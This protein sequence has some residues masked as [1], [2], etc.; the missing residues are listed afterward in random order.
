LRR[1]WLPVV[2]FTALLLSAVPAP[3]QVRPTTAAIQWFPSITD[4]IAAKPDSQLPMLLFLWDPAERWDARMQSILVDS[5]A[6][7]GLLQGF[8]PV[9]LKMPGAKQV[10]DAYGLRS[11]P[12]LAVVSPSGRVLGS[13]LGFQDEAGCREFL[14]QS[15]GPVGKAVVAHDLQQ[16]L[17]KLHESRPKALD[18]FAD[19]DWVNL[20][21]AMGSPAWRQEVRRMMLELDPFPAAKLVEHLEHPRLAVRL[22][23][24]ELLEERAGDSLDFDPWQPGGEASVEALRKW[25]EWAQQPAGEATRRSYAAITLADIAECL[26]DLASADWARAARAR[27]RLLSGGDGTVAAAAAYLERNPG[28]PAGTVQLLR[29]VQFAACLQ[30]A[31]TVDGERLARQLAFGDLD[32]R[33]AAVPKLARASLAAVPILRQLLLSDEPLVREVAADTLGAIGGNTAVA[34]LAEHLHAE[35]DVD[36]VI[37]IASRL[38]KCRTKRSMLTLDGLLKH[39]DEDVRVA[40][41]EALGRFESSL[42]VSE[43]I[44]AAL[45]DESWRTRAGA[46]ACIGES[47]NR[48]YSGQIA[49][50]LDDE[51]AFVRTS[52]VTALARMDLKKHLPLLE[53]TY[54]AQGDLRPIL[55]PLLAREGKLS[56]EVVTSLKTESSET[57]QQMLAGLA[58]HDSSGWGLDRPS[59]RTKRIRAAQEKIAETALESDNVE[60]RAVAYGSYARMARHSDK[61]RGLTVQALQSEER[62]VRME[63]LRSLQMSMISGVLAESRKRMPGATAGEGASGG[64][65]DGDGNTAVDE[66][67]D[68]FGDSPAEG[69]APGAPGSIDLG[70]DTSVD[71]LLEAFGLEDKGPQAGTAGNDEIPPQGGTQEGNFMDELAGAFGFESRDGKEEEGQTTVE[72]EKKPDGKSW[73]T[74]NEEQLYAILLAGIDVAGDDEER[75]LAAYHVVCSGNPDPFPL[76][77][78]GRTHLSGRQ[79]S[80][81][82]DRVFLFADF[83]S[84]DDLAQE[85]IR[86]SDGETRGEFCGKLLETGRPEKWIELAFEELAK[87]G[88]TVSAEDFD[89][90]HLKRVSRQPRLAKTFR[91]YARKLAQT[92]EQDSEKYAMAL[93]MLLG[94]TDEETVDIFRK[95]RE[96]TSA[97]VRALAWIGLGS[98]DFDT[99]KADCAL[100][101]RDED[102]ALRSILPMIICEGSI[103]I[104]GEGDFQVY[105]DEE[106][107]GRIRRKLVFSGIEEIDKVLNLLAGDVEA[108]IRLQAMLALAILGRPVA[109]DALSATIAGFDKSPAELVQRAFSYKHRRTLKRKSPEVLQVLVEAIPALAEYFDIESSRK[110]VTDETTAQR[111][112]PPALADMAQQYDF[113]ENQADRG[114]EEVSPRVG[115]AGNDLTDTQE[116]H[117]DTGG[118]VRLI[119]FFKPGC[120]DCHR[121]DRMIRAVLDGGMRVQPEKWNINTPE[122]IRL[123]QVLCNRFDIP[124]ENRRVAPAVFTSAGALIRKEITKFSLADLIAMAEHDRSAPDWAEFTPGDAENAEQEIRQDFDRITL[125]IVI[126]NG[127]VDGINPCAFAALVFLLSYLTVTRRTTAAVLSVGGAY[128][129]AVFLTYLLLGVGLAGLAE[130]LTGTPLAAALVRGILLGMLGLLAVLS[131][132]DALICWRGGAEKMSLRLPRF[133]TRLVHARIRHGAKARFILPAAFATG[134]IVSLLE[135]AC[136]GQVYL[137]TILFVLGT[138]AARSTAFSWLVL[139]NLA[140]VVPLVAVFA[141]YAGG[142]RSQPLTAW[143]NRHAVLAKLLMTTVFLAMLVLLLAKG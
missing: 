141:L 19:A 123:N 43:A 66:L 113:R 116:A 40:A 98:A 61:A 33:L 109:V 54:L 90:W 5:K 117:S 81:L 24:V 142:L 69:A 80:N 13:R 89:S 7:D 16:V 12:A 88:G 78:D 107:T 139:Y 95:G 23:A 26:D 126:V 77:K 101:A 71:E 21:V 36:V 110:E 9:S 143:F 51:D 130:R 62:Q 57:L 14:L 136:T 84:A 55:I 94:A 137:P 97:C 70:G 46:V 75:A 87:P 11:T 64:K 74:A 73:P 96:S 22:G 47:E 100:L 63:A 59:D 86:N 120:G 35:D 125:G 119:V 93:C 58:E 138:S 134:M 131:L 104:G 99:F 56:D 2:V 135:L 118:P 8:V 124:P 103:S 18:S 42:Q 128:T 32:A 20:L 133:L 27:R 72:G 60:L 10:A 132:R 121:V 49:A 68:L 4:A 25:Q 85:M 112:L 15:L 92:S 91:P 30:K 53:K 48:K 65:D 45:E 106:E 37:T 3:G 67:L 140:F 17:T 39:E 44:L 114:S 29:E 127:L 28:L 102:K 6:L 82:L 38:G 122:G 76:L 115:E 105:V 1:V 50:R 31:P 108:E 111:E 79:R 52:A 34:V 129:L 41:L 83:P